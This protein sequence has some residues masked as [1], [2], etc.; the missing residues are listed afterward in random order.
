MSFMKRKLVILFWGVLFC[1]LCLGLLYAVEDGE[2]DVPAENGFTP[3]SQSV[4]Q[5]HAGIDL[6]DNAMKSYK[7]SLW[8]NDVTV[9]TGTVYGGIDVVSDADF[10]M[11][12]ARCTTYND[13]YSNMIIVYKST[14]EGQNWSHFTSF[15]STENAHY[16]YPQLEVSSKGDSTFLYVFA[17]RDDLNGRIR[18]RRYS[19]SGALSFKMDVVTGSSDTITYYSVCSDFDGDSLILVYEEHQTSDVTPDV[20]SIRTTNYGATWFDDITVET[21]GAHPDVAFGADRYAYMVYQTTLS[22]DFEIELRRT[23]NGGDNWV[24]AKALTV[25]TYT[26]DYPKVVAAHTTPPGSAC[27][28]VTY[29]HDYAN[30]GNID[31][32]FVYSTDGGN[33]WSSQRSLANSSTYDEQASNVYT[34]KYPGWSTVYVCYLEYMMTGVFP[35]FNETSR[36]Y[37]AYAT[38]DDPD[39]WQDKTQVSDNLAAYSRDGREICQGAFYPCWIFPVP[40]IVY[41][42]KPDIWLV[43][44]DGLYFD[45]YCFVGVEETEDVKIDPEDFS[46]Y[47]NYPNPFNPETRISYSLPQVSHVKLEIFNILGQRIR[48]MVDEDQTVGNKEVTWDGKN[49]V[50]ENVASGVYFYRLQAKD[51]VQ[52]KKMVLIR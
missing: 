12:A 24:T 7:T 36:I 29:N 25:D 45:G 42:G 2:M 15:Y 14:N 34:I 51:F 28:W 10:N 5:K 23:T 41:A 48:M 26:D 32:R 13:I 9:G 31:V 33:T 21:D 8:G 3:A 19:L 50:G 11:Y 49:E 37:T 6:S 52:T 35:N 20:H 30:S 1:F 17:L 44:F 40:G 38:A 18:L 27:V 22:D 47:D 16:S 39:N 43:N 46:L 4:L